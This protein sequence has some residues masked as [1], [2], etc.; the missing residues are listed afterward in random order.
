M[1]NQPLWL[2]RV[3]RA[4]EELESNPDPWVDR[5]VVETLLGVGRRRAQQLLAPLAR[6]RI[7]TSIVADRDQI[8]H[9]LKK[10]AAGEQAHY[11]ERR[12]KQLWDRIQQLRR[13]WIEQPPVLVEISDTQIRQVE[14]HDFHGLPE[15]IELAPGSITIRFR[16][17]DEALQKLMALAMAIGQNRQAFDERVALR[18]IESR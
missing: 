11:E 2:H 6:R 10:V 4:I 5:R 12:R 9:H 14:M 13:Q 1:P 8:I 17:A 15:G 16:E 18:P 3:A 7:G